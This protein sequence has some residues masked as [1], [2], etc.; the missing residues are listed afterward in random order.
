MFGDFGKRFAA[1]LHYGNTGLYLSD[2]LDWLNLWQNNANNEQGLD[3]NF[4]AQQDH[5]FPHP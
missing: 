1:A 4:S 3:D 2:T 5:Y